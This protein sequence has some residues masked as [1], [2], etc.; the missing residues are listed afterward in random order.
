L[1]NEWQIIATEQMLTTKRERERETS[2]GKINGQSKEIFPWSKS[3]CGISKDFAS[4]SK[5][6]IQNSLK[7][8]V[9]LYAVL[10]VVFN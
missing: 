5:H 6:L 9:C 2:I 3:A 8:C 10:K 1:A 4:W 7:I